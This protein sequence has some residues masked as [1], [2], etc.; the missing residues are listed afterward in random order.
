MCPERTPVRLA[1][2]ERFELPT[3][4][5][6]IREGI[7]RKPYENRGVRCAIAFESS[8]ICSD[9]ALG[10][11]HS[12][13]PPPA[14]RAV[15]MTPFLVISFHL[16]AALTVSP[17]ACLP[18]A[19]LPVCMVARSGSGQLPVQSPG[20]SGPRHEWVSPEL[21][22]GRPSD[23][24]IM[25]RP[26]A[27]AGRRFE[28]CHEGTTSNALKLHGCCDGLAAA[29]WRQRPGVTPITRLKA[30]WNVVHDL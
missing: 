10:A 19:V 13:N 8:C 9:C 25:R 7:G 1:H 23:G 21:G 24:A 15:S 26:P 30:R 16:G 17:S 28:M 29:P 12:Y 18:R 27:V 11:P 14:S 3:L 4:G 6:E 5:I 20:M 22:L 2:S